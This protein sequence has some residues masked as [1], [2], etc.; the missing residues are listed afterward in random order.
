MVLE[1]LALTCAHPKDQSVGVT[2]VYSRRYYPDQGNSEFL[3]KALSV[4]N[5][6]DFS[7][8]E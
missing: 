4:F 7:D 1:A 8:L 5:S 3:E 6:L 2:V